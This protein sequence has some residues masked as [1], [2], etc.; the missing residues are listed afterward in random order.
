MTFKM[1]IKPT[2]PIRNKLYKY[3]KYYPC[4]KPTL[5]EIREQ[6][7]DKAICHIKHDDYNGT[8]IVFDWY[9]LEDE[10]SFQ[11]RIHKY[12]E[13]M[14]KYNEWQKEYKEQIKAYKVRK[15]KRIK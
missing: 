14:K 9:E 7:S 1:R 2:A 4:D 6:V 12:K 11:K 13:V 10:Q 15:M 3:R 5:K 8:S